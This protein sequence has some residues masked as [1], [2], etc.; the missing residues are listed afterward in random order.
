M[1]YHPLNIVLLFGGNF[2]ET[3]ELIPEAKRR[4]LATINSKVI[5]ESKVVKTKPWGNTNQ[6]DFWNGILVIEGSIQPMDLLS[7]IKNIEADLGRSHSKHDRYG[8]RNID[9]D[10]LALGETILLSK[11]LTIPHPR[12][13]ERDFVKDLLSE[14]PPEILPHVLTTCYT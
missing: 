13:A 8:P 7:F 11:L 10:I 14:V 5:F 3:P 2:P 9:I 12:I 6:A 4:L 1:G